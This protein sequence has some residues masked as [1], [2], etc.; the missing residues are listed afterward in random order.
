MRTAPLALLTVLLASGCPGDD[1]PKNPDVLWLALDG[2][3]T[4]VHL[5][6]TEPMPF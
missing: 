6:A 5:L 3:E 4:Q 1:E 2:S